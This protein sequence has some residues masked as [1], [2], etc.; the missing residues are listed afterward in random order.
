MSL[1]IREIV[2]DFFNGRGDIPGSTDV[3]KLACMYLDVGLLD[4]F[5]LVDMVLEIEEKCGFRFE[6][7]Q[8]QSREFRTIGGVIAISEK[9]AM[10]Y[11]DA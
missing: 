11:S 9:L 7:E 8:M 1:S 2:L 10:E 4:S 5:G 3:E 6:A